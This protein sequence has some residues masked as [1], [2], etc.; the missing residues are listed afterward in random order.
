MHK[1]SPINKGRLPFGFY[2]HRLLT[3]L[4]Q[5]AARDCYESFICYWQWVQMNSSCYLVATRWTAWLGPHRPNKPRPAIPVLP[6]GFLLWKKN[7]NNNKKSVHHIFFPH[8]GAY[9][10][11]F[12]WFFW[13]TSSCKLNLI[14]R[15]NVYRNGL[16]NLKVFTLKSVIGQ[17]FTGLYLPI[18]LTLH[19]ASTSENYVKIR[20]LECSS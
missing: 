2:D 18:Q 10:F 4:G 6:T 16:A 20:L 15:Y 7:N 14:Q 1:K 3:I 17:E 11:V 8:N 12:S 19:A 9:Y 5:V 13:I